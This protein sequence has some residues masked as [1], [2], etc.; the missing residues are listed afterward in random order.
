MGV[1]KLIFKAFLNYMNCEDFCLVNIGRHEP[2]KVQKWGNREL[3]GS[4]VIGKNVCST[5]SKLFGNF[6][7]LKHQSF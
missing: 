6:L 3:L 2:E 5:F 4:Y 7:N 1:G